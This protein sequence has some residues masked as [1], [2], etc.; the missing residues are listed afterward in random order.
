[1]VT[2]C[3]IPPIVT[4]EASSIRLVCAS[5]HSLSTTAAA[6][7]KRVFLMLYLLIYLTKSALTGRSCD[8]LAFVRRLKDVCPPSRRRHV[9]KGCQT[10]GPGYYNAP[11]GNGKTQPRS[12]AGHVGRD[13]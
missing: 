3:S 5:T 10:V 1:M 8:G 11:H 6:R 2:H 4:K 7:S 12:A 9:P 13:Q